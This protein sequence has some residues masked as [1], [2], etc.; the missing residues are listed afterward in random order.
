MAKQTLQND[1]SLTAGAETFNIERLPPVKKRTYTRL[2]AGFIAWLFMLPLVAINL[3]VILGPSIASVYY[4]L[5]DWDGL[6]AAKFIGLQNYQRMLGDSEFQ[7]ALLHNIIWTVIFLTVPIAMG[8]LGA[9][10]LSQIT[11]F[12]MFFRVVYFIPYMVASVVNASIWQDLLNP[13]RGLGGALAKIGIP[14]LK[15]I[16]FFGDQRYALG[17]VAFVDNWHFWGFLVVLF[18]AAMQAVDTT[19]YEAARIDG[20]NRWQQFY[21]VTLPGI[22]PTL[23]FMILMILIWSL[24]VFDYIF[25]ITQGGPGGAT[26]V[27]STL[28]YKN[29]FSRNDAGYAAAMGL[30]MTFISAIVVG[31]YFYLRRK[32]WDI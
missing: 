16:Y 1:L 3:L 18:L 32:G 10:L 12:Q 9:F 8:L 17:A 22:R 15:D 30:S 6:G 7:Q 29:A 14:F 24:V 23:V 25:I 13:D 4:S 20:A 21:N 31:G 28:L 2:R 5:T 11:R 27:V 19:L 26:E